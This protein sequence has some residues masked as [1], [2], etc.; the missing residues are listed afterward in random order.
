[1]WRCICYLIYWV[2][3]GTWQDRCSSPS[4]SEITSQEKSLLLIRSVR[5]EKK[6]IGKKA[7][8]NVGNMPAFN[9]MEKLNLV[10]NQPFLQKVRKEDIRLNP[11][12]CGGL[13][14]GAAIKQSVQM[15]WEWKHNILPA[16]FSLAQKGQEIKGGGYL[17]QLWSSKLRCKNNPYEERIWADGLLVLAESQAG[18]TSEL[19]WALSWA[20]R[21]EQCRKEHQANGTMGL[22]G[23]SSSKSISSV[24]AEMQRHRGSSDC[25]GRW[26]YGLQMAGEEVQ[27]PV[28]PACCTGDEHL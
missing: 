23:C 7:L 18:V 20:P 17:A 22:M 19:E 3:K 10:F 27:Y 25:S 13:E 24:V 4:P 12:A 26:N 9:P 5:N 2:L 1:M 6:P 16:P 15:P 21:Q 28:W 8:L 11:G 14:D